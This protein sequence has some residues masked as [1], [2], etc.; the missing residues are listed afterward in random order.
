MKS[1]RAL[2][3]AKKTRLIRKRTPRF[4]RYAGRVLVI[5]RPLGFAYRAV[6]ER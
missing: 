3:G 4:L 6:S 1:G 2:T 5:D